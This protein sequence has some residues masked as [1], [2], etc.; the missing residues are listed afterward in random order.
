MGIRFYHFYL[1]LFFQIFL[2]ESAS[3]SLAGLLP[4][5]VLDLTMEEEV[6]VLGDL[7]LVGG[8]LVQVR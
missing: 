4:G 7:L 3:D 2:L 6:A 5:L 8:K 1:F